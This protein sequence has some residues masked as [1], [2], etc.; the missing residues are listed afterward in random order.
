MT[1]KR[2]AFQ[3]SVDLMPS[4]PWRHCVR[5][6]LYFKRERLRAVVVAASLATV[7]PL[8]RGAASPP[9]VPLGSLLPAGGGDG[10]RGFVLAGVD[11][12]DR[13]GKS[14]SA[15]GDVNG[16]GIDDVIIGAPEGYP[17]GRVEA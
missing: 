13:S 14:V 9:V 10:S 17:G 8:A 5:R 2:E 6:A 7:T 11:E 1:R 4:S 3:R 15:A 12:H 16:D